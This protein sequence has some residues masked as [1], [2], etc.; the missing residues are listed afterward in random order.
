VRKVIL[1]IDAL[2]IL[3]GLGTSL[4]VREQLN[5]PIPP[6]SAASTFPDSRTISGQAPALPWPPQGAAAVSVPNLGVV[7]TFG[8]NDTRP[9]AS[10]A[11]VM[12]AHVILT[13]HPLTL[14]DQG[15]SATVTQEDINTYLQGVRNGESVVPVTVGQRLTQYQMLQALMLPSGNNIAT[16]LGRWDA[17]TIE[18]FVAKMNVKARELGMTATNFADASGYSPRTTSTPSDLIRLGRAAMQDPVFREIVSQREAT[19]PGSGR[20]FNVNTSLGTDGNI[21]IKTGSTPEA[22]SCLLFAAMRSVAGQELMIVGAVLDQPLL[23]DAFERSAR[24][25]VAAGSGVQ[26]TRVLS[27]SEVIGTYTA[28]WGGEV[29]VVPAEAVDFIS[30]PGTAVQIDVTLNPITTPSPKGAKAGT[31]TMALG[32]Q[33]KTVDLLTT[34]ILPEPDQNWRLMRPFRALGLVQ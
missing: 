5:Y 13:D 33:S 4:F 14:G 9:I 7:G 34:G 29:E 21:G 31:I 28:P 3:F 23:S 17:G 16:M 11:K 6:V 20:V 25:A 15:S 26:T 22:G 19:I 24:L 10:I 27:Q 1:A 32:D 8:G 30:W 2:L 18:A 12:T